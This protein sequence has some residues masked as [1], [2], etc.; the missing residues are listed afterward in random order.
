[1]DFLQ[2]DQA[3][4][5]EEE[6]EQIDKT[7]YEVAKNTLIGRRFIPVVGPIG[8]G[9]QVISYDVLYGVEP[10][11]CEIRPGQEYEVCEP[12]RTGI[13]KHVPIPTLYKEFVIS[14]RDLQHWRQ[15]NLPIDTTNAAAAASALAVAEDTLIIFGNNE[16]GIEGLLTAEGV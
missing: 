7:V 8:A 4:L 10:G 13:R 12:I 9:H 5:T 14:W 2:R 16:L 3:P 1:M 15:F 6:W 11:I